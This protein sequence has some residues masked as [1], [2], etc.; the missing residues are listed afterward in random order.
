ML[1]FV[2]LYHTILLLLTISKESTQR[3][4][5]EP[6]SFSSSC[7]SH[8]NPGTSLSKYGTNELTSKLRTPNFTSKCQRHDVIS[9]WRTPNLTFKFRAN[10][11]KSRTQYWRRT[12]PFFVDMREI[13]GYSTSKNMSNLQ[14]SLQTSPENM[15]QVLYFC[16]TFY[17]NHRLDL[18]FPTRNK[19]SCIQHPIYNPPQIITQT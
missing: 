12:L 1:H 4:I 11:V 17:W 10:C 16:V 13:K 14:N 15:H 6:V 8:L 7:H 3:W 9:K 2:N 18:P 5:Y 19:R